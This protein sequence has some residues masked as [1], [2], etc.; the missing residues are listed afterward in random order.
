MSMRSLQL[1]RATFDIGLHCFDGIFENF[2]NMKLSGFFSNFRGLN[3]E[4]Y[5]LFEATF[6]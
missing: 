3:D 1:I 6:E 5:Q 2:E 4:S